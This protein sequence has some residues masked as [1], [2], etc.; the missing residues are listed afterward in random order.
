MKG[1]SEEKS[2]LSYSSEWSPSSQTDRRTHRGGGGGGAVALPQ[3]KDPFN[4][5]ACS[6][7]RGWQSSVLSSQPKT[8]S[9]PPLPPNKQQGSF[10]LQTSASEESLSP[11][12]KEQEKQLSARK[13]RSPLPVRKERRLPSTDRDHA[14]QQPHVPRAAQSAGTRQPSTT[15]TRTSTRLQEQNQMQWFRRRVATP[16][17]N[18]SPPPSLHR[19]KHGTSASPI[20]RHR[21]G[22]ATTPI[23]LLPNQQQGTD[24]RSVL[25][26]QT[27]FSYEEQD[28]SVQNQCGNHYEVQSQNSTQ[29][30]RAS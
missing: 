6:R 18:T 29:Y 14:S 20:I 13:R 3:K 27:T 21:K 19:R 1:I 25:E 10:T 9:M 4:F 15:T 28:Q 22:G 5:N 2:S 12:S 17:P 30:R 26:N 8:H 23:V 11:P 24:P 7:E 16:P